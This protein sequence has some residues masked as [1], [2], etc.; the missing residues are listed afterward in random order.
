MARTMVTDPSKGETLN[1]I[2]LP[3]G[4]GRKFF[5][6]GR[7][8][9]FP[10][11]TVVCHVAKAGSLLE[12]LDQLY[13]RLRTAKAATLYTLLPPTSWHMTV[14]DCV[15][16]EERDGH[17]WPNG[18]ALDLPLAELNR[19]FEERLKAERFGPKLDFAMRV[20]GCWP[21]RQVISIALEPADSAEEQAIR[22]LRNRL[23]TALGLRRH[24]HDAYGFHI[25]LAYFRDY[26]RGGDLVEL[27]HILTEETEAMTASLPPFVLGPPEFCDF[28]DMFAFSRRLYLR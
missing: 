13:D 20:T 1:G 8:R 21:L 12:R 16:D 11:S 25:T 3:I 9:A 28:N 4:V 2:A 10:G 7:V 23:A 19:E 14:F 6:D 5:P 24:N 22:T 15:C 18:K 26:P 17:N 27:E